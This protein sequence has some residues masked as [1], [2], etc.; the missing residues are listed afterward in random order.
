MFRGS[1]NTG[2]RVPSFNQIFNG[3]TESDLNTG[4]NVADPRT[5]PHTDRAQSGKTPVAR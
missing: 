3:R 4:A 2:F 5:C 1:Y